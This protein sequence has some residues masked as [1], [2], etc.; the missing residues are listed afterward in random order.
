MSIVNMKG[1]LALSTINNKPLTSAQIR[2]ERA[3]VVPGRV[4]GAQLFTFL[5]K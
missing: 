5:Y 2:L 3:F 1:K 4:F